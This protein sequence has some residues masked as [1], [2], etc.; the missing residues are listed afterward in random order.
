MAFKG[1]DACLDKAEAD[2]PLFTLLA[3][4]VSAAILV[5]LWA[6]LREQRDGLTEQVVEAR[7]CASKMR[8]WRKRNRP[9]RDAG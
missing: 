8:L 3:R 5:E 7:T 4:D 1:K 6:S 9:E 2:E